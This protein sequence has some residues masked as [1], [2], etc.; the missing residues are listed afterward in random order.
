MPGD[1]AGLPRVGAG[2]VGAHDRQPGDLGPVRAGH[3]RDGRGVGHDV[4]D[5][6]GGVVAVQRHVRRT[7]AHHGDQRDHQLRRPRQRHR[8]RALGTCA[9]RAQPA[10]Q[11]RRACVQLR[12]GQRRPAR[13]GDGDPVRMGGRGPLEQLR[14]RRPVVARAGHR[15]L[16]LEHGPLGGQQRV[17][18]ADGRVRVGDHAVEHGQVAVEQP[19]GGRRVEHVGAVAQLHHR[20]RPGPHHEPRRVVRG[21]AA[22]HGPDGQ[23][24]RG[25][26]GGEH[27][28]VDGVVLERGERVEQLRVPGERR[29]LGEPDVLGVEQVGLRGLQG[30]QCV[31]HRA[32][33]VR[34]DPHRHG[35]DEEPQH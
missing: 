31:E 1:Q 2:V 32:A 25:L 13:H 5:A 15:G 18:P 11:P 22:G 16:G 12:V 27:V 23:P 10:G 17:E 33:R 9:Q 24:G 7:G 14:E 21:V 29:D 26:G 20:A 4:R 34:P 30:A 28:G 8:D 19:G 35:V 6:V 3:E